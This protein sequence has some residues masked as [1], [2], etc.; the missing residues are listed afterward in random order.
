MAKKDDAP[1]LNPALRTFWQT[2]A[3]NR[4]LY[5]GRASSKTWDAGGMA[6][7]LA[8]RYKA[9]FLCTRQFQNRIE[10]SVYSLLKLQIER[11]GLQKHFAVYKNRIECPATGSDFL[12]YGR[13]RNLNEIKGTEGVDVHWG[14]ECELLTKEE[15]RIIDA[16]VRAEDSQHWLIFNPKFATDFVYQRFVVNPPPETVKR[17]INYPENPF[18]S[19]TMRRV[20]AACQEETPEDYEHVYLG[21]PLSD[22]D[23]VLIK[24]R[25]I[26]AAVDAHIK[27]GF[28]PGGTHRVGF[29]VADDGDDQCATVTAKG[30]LVLTADAWNAW[31]DELLQSC[32]RVYEHAWPLR[33]AV[34]YDCI[35]V[36]A[37][38]GAKFNELNI[39]ERNQAFR[40]EHNGFDAGGAVER[41]LEEYTTGRQNRDHFSNLKAQ[42]WQEVA[43]RFRNTF[44]AVTRG[45]IF[46]VDQMI[47]LSSACPNLDKLK[48]E[49]S[50]PFKT[51][52]QNGRVQVETKKALRARKVA[53]P[54]LAD[55]A[56]MCLAGHRPSVASVWAKLGR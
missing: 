3:R 26:E 34:V 27:L 29:D 49:L 47:S 33:A 7:F 48:T 23:R 35:G 36:G 28:D 17:L 54:N 43:D 6:V 38:C 18:L 55:A 8:H 4:V 2:R 41:P 22:N 51:F 1:S 40:V 5:G 13:C 52:D 42:K 9:R 30:S 50:T 37:H 25:W 21:V 32:T 46:P 12:F 19:Q 31:E 14:E 56:I 24:R 45:R 53:S 39:L 44:E 16:T 11:F 20:I 15:W 10:D